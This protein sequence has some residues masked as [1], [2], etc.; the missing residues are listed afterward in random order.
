MLASDVPPEAKLRLAILYALRYQKTPGNAISQTVK[1]L[2]Q[3][4]VDPEDAEVS[5]SIFYSVVPTHFTLSSWFMS[6]LIWLVWSKGRMISL[7]MR[8][9]SLEAGPH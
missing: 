9:F 5:F 3:N 1:M 2:E 7:P 6:C 4:G 8:I